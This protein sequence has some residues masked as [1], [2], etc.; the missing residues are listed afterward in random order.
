MAL[1]YSGKTVYVYGLGRSGQASIS[2]LLDDGATVW[3]WD[4]SELN[5][6]SDFPGRTR[7]EV[8]APDDVEWVEVDAVMKSP[9]ISFDNPLV[10]S[11]QAHDI[12]IIGDIDL[13]YRR[14][15]NAKFIG[16]TGTNGKS[17]T[18]A[19]IAHVLASAGYDAV[20]GGNIG[21]PAMQIPQLSNDGIYVLELSSYQL[22]M[23]EELQL[24]AAV[25]LNL[26]PDH[27]DRHQ[28]MEQYM[29][30]K[31]KVFRNCKEG[32]PKSCGVDN[33]LVSTAVS[34]FK[35]VQTVTMNGAQA[36]YRVSQDGKLMHNGAQIADLTYFTHLPG[37]HNWQNIT[38]A[39]LA[40]SPWVSQDGFFQHLRS[41]RPL[42]HRMERVQELDGV[43]FINDSKA[44]NPESANAA[45]QSFPKIYWIAGG[46]AKAEGVK[47]CLN[48][49][50][51][52]QAA[53]VIGE[54]EEDFAQVLEPHVPVF[55]CGSLENAVRSA[56]QSAREE[57]MEGAVVLLAPACASFDQFDSF[58]HRGDSFANL[59]R[60]LQSEG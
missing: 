13:L 42:P 36:E 60:Q 16:V 10:T 40:C 30:A 17:T 46:Q 29:A 58:E 24:D 51:S 59:C 41:F 45:L 50:K 20:A 9:G 38:C 7:V 56:Y 3:V 27:L 37:P 26:S 44:T 33:P 15:P 32:A 39:L 53:F 6:G 54:S 11:A 1:G 14:S 5:R 8:L 43:A 48:Y 57:G 2:A 12:P 22:E 55:R 4:D 21:K 31:L 18:T 49:L 19:M 28:K 34:A 47:P 52:V 23:V 35:D 25:F